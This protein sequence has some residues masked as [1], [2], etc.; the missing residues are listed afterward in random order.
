MS[1]ESEGSASPS[2]S[3]RS[4]SASPIA[5]RSTPA[6]SS[7]NIAAPSPRTKVEVASSL[8]PAR[9]IQ[10]APS[11]DEFEDDDVEEFI[12]TQQPEITQ[13]SEIT[14]QPEISVESSSEPVPS[15]SLQPEKT[16]SEEERIQEALRD[17]EMMMQLTQDFQDDDPDEVLGYTALGKRKRA[18][19][20]NEKRLA[21][22]PCK[23]FEGAKGC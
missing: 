18:G 23:I 4:R 7:L 19:D 16:K 13:Q 21:K 22:W 12:L 5:R 6:S 8:V 1:P 14:Q 17:E 20:S 10:S 15:S 3:L 2:P 9:Y 11:D